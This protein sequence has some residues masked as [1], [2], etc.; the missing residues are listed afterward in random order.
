MNRFTDTLYKEMQQSLQQAAMDTEN[1]LRRAECSFRI[2]ESF[3]VRLR[4]FMAAYSFSDEQEEV[5]FFK[6]VKP[7]FQK[8][9]F[10][11]A[12]VM[13]VEAH[14]PVCGKRKI[15]H[16]LNGI[17]EGMAM[18]F[19][20]HHFLHTYC[21]KGR[22]DKDTMLFLRHAECPDLFPEVMPDMDRT[23]STQGS[24]MLARLM[25][26]EEITQW[27]NAKLKVSNVSHTGKEQHGL[28]WTGSK[29]QLIE[30]VYALES[31]G[32][33]N[34]GKTNVKEV[35]EYLQSCFHVDRVSNF[36]GY[37]QSM[38]IRKKDRTPFLKGLME[39]TLR[40]MDESDEFPRFA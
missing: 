4:D 35:M 3:L 40:R 36:Y 28:T 37:F 26:M 2:A 23:F 17:Q 21:R 18:F 19:C 7:R 12:E 24:T 16:Y 8:E 33:F 30:L 25:A 22:T 27:L 6:A 11:W 1:L 32:V 38:R 9:L 10:Y 31:Y 15:K 20:R 34:N 5:L 39:H 29:A 14:Q 13:Q